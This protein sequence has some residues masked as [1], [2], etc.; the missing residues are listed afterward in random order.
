MSSY[1]T[2]MIRANHRRRFTSMFHTVFK[3]VAKVLV[4]LHDASGPVCFSSFVM[5]SVDGG[6]QR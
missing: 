3:Q 5:Y 2:V 4:V 1:S 6:H